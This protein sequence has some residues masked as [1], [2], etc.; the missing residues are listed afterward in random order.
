MAD[1]PIL[2]PTLEAL[3]GT[4]SNPTDYENLSALAAVDRQ[5]R[6]WLV[7]FL[8]TVVDSTS[9]TFKP[10]AFGEES[11]P[12][13]S[14]R[15]TTDNIAGEQREVLQGSISTPDLRD[16]SVTAGK[17]A[18]DAVTTAKIEDN[19][20]TEAKILDA[21][22]TEDKIA[23]NAVTGAKIPDGT[24]VTAKLDDLAVTAAKIADATITAA[25]LAAN[26]V[27]GSNLP[28]GSAGQVLLHN[29]TKYVS[30]TIT[31]ALSISSAGVATVS[32]TGSAAW[33]RISEQVASGTNGG[34]SVA[35]NW[36]QKRGVSTVWTIDEQT[37]AGTVSLGASGKINIT[38]NGVY[39]VD[40]SVPG[41]SV[42]SHKAKVTYTPTSGPAVNYISS[43]E[44]AGPGTQ[45]SCRLRFLLTVSGASAGSP[46]TLDIYHWTELAKGTNGLGLASGAA[47]EVERYAMVE[48]LRVS[49]T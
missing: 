28:S 37:V 23:A 11:I 12:V 3:S 44:C 20:V 25:K 40:V 47:T 9:G 43:V 30:T 41:Y 42:G 1:Y 19:A 32:I 26:A 36:T 14:V 27:D 21:A 46:A 15:G 45:T 39:L 35:T 13:G 22:V 5:T 48:M 10:G 8:S 33:V 31:G 17:I 34:S 16:E 4:A 49:T 2:A 29:G 18:T 24:I 7:D 38:A 6:R